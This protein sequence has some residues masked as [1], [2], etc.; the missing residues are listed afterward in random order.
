MISRIL[1]HVH[2]PRTAGQKFR[3]FMNSRV[4]V[5]EWKQ[6]HKSLSELRE[7]A[8]KH[9]PDMADTIPSFCVTRN[10][11]DWYVSRYFH[12]QRDIQA[13][14]RKNNV[15]LE[16]AGNDVEGFQK[17]LKLLKEVKEGDRIVRDTDGEVG[18]TGRTWWHLSI[19]EWHNHLTESNVDHILRFENRF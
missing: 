15:L 11:W 12:I 19:S 6:T 10:P 16:H 3:A 18:R 17:H 5:L 4:G 13:G 8:R 1:L 14:L 7:L 2:I 9:W